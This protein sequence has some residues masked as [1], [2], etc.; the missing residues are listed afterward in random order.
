MKEDDYS[1]EEG[2]DILDQQDE[3]I[4]KANNQLNEIR[5]KNKKNVKGQKQTRQERDAK[6]QRIREENKKKNDEGRA[7]REKNRQEIRKK[8]EDKKKAKENQFNNLFSEFLD[9]ENDLDNIIAPGQNDQYVFNQEEWDIVDEAPVDEAAEQRRREAEQKAWEDEEKQLRAEADQLVKDY[10]QEEQRR[11]QEEQRRQQE[12]QQRQQGRD[13]YEWHL[14]T[15]RADANEGFRSI[16]SVYGPDGRLP[17]GLGYEHPE[18]FDDIQLEVPEGFSKELIAAIVIGAAMDRSRLNENLSEPV[19]DADPINDN[20]KHFLNGILKGDPND[21]NFVPIMILAKKEAAQAIKEYKENGT[22]KSIKRYLRNYAD[23]AA[24]NSSELDAS[25]GIDTEEITTSQLGQMLCQKYVIDGKFK[26]EPNTHDTT[27]IQKL[28]LSSYSKQMDSLMSAQSSKL[29]LVNEAATLSVQ[30]KEAL[31]EEM[32][33]NSFI[34]N[35]A[36]KSRK[37]IPQKVADNQKQAFRNIGID[38]TSPDWNGTALKQDGKT[39]LQAKKAANAYSRNQITEFEALTGAPTGINVI[40]EKYREAIKNSDLYRNVVNANSKNAMLDALMAVEKEST[41]GFKETFPD[42]NVTEYSFALNNGRKEK[43][44]EE[45]KEVR[46]ATVDASLSEELT[47][48]VNT[49]G[50]LSLNPQA[51]TNNARMIEEIYQTVKGNNY[52]GGSPNYDNMKNKLEELRN[53]TR[54]LARYN[55]TIGSMDAKKYQKLVKEF[56]DL[57]EKYLTEKTTVSGSYARNRVAGVKNARLKILASMPNIDHAIKTMQEDKL[58]EVI[59][60]KFKNYDDFSS[61]NQKNTYYGNKY[62]SVHSRTIPFGAKKY[63]LGRTAGIS[64]A[65]LALAA[66]GEYTLEDL[67]D[68]EKKKNEKAEMFDKVATAMKNSNKPENQKWIAEQ[69]YKGQKAT[70]KI[71]NEEMKYVDFSNPDVL[72]DKKMGMLCN[73]YEARFD[74]EQELTRECSDEYIAIARKENPNIR[75][76]ADIKVVW[77][78]LTDISKTINTMKKY[79][80]RAATEKNPDVLRDDVANLMACRPKIDAYLKL[81]DDT[82]EEKGDTPVNEW[83]PEGTSDEFKLKVDGMA[84]AITDTGKYLG[85]DPKMIK[86]LMPKLIDGSYMKNVKVEPAPEIGAARI[87]SGFP[88]ETRM[89]MDSVNMVFLKNTDAALQRLK[90]QHY[91]NKKDFVMDSAYAIFGQMYRAAGGRMPLDAKT[92]KEITLDKYMEIQLKNGIFEKS[93]KS[94]KNP[95]EFTRPVDV[96]A[97]AENQEKMRRL[98][99]KNINAALDKK[100]IKKNNNTVVRSNTTRTVSSGNTS[101]TQL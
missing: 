61:E 79:A 81:M 13:E 60:D 4:R 3:E 42:I 59:G 31:A 57:S 5:K 76:K 48:N 67:M 33:L 8:Y 12:E 11:Q 56:D 15:F 88:T 35:I 78:P 7:R 47:Y 86:N 71:F 25:K 89:K 98:I 97:Y 28:R 24:G 52:R 45:L 74:A 93:L 46:K 50:L 95:K 34:S 22:D 73:L 37:D 44:S 40:K 1:R 58:E 70:D 68:P 69:I 16:T 36:T 83:F 17:R 100:G 65:M 94:K 66:T 9:D 85:K 43:L 82:R 30:Q 54:D 39:A 91:T 63:T 10:Q 64:V 55:D 62:R 87:T 32:I 6:R 18:E 38:E 27:K 80:V 23:Y 90:T 92:G 53:Y 96:A 21:K 14:N 84:K 26:V 41:K 19:T 49:Y 2:Q 20:R 77:S 75:T 29:K 51:V 101:I 99:Q 72:K